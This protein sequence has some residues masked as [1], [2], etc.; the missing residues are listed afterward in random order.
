MKKFT[1]RKKELDQLQK[2]IV[3]GKSEFIAVYGR[4]RIGKTYLIRQAFSGIFTFHVTALSNADYLMQLANFNVEL[5]KLC[6]EEH[7]KP[8]S[9][10]LDAFES[11]RYLLEKNF[12]EKKRKVIFLDELPWFDT[13]NSGFIPALEH[14]WNHWAS[15][16]KDIIL[17]VCGSAA[18]WM[19]NK[20]IN[21]K[22]GLHNRITLK[23][24]VFP[25][26]LNE[27][28][29][30]LLSD[31]MTLDRYQITQ[32]YMVL[33]G[34]PFYWDQVVKGKSAV[35]NINDICFTE[36]GLLR[37]EFNNLFRSL[38]DNYQKHEAVIKAI[39]SKSSGLTRDDIIRKTG[40]PNAGST[41]RIL[42][43]LEESGFLNK[44]SPYGKKERNSL[45]QLTDNY[46]LFYFKFLRDIGK[47][48][49]AS[50]ITH[51]DTPAYRAWSGYAF[52]TIC[53]KHIDQIKHSLGISGVQTAVSSWRCNTRNKGVQIDL[54][55]DR[56][57]M[58]IN[59]CEMKF[60]VN[61]FV[62]NKKYQN[63]LQNKISL[64]REETGTRKALF[65]TFITTFG[66]DSASTGSGLVQNS[67][68]LD[69]LFIQND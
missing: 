61:K 3:S 27:C 20:L 23:I 44:F 2:A 40:L 67:L 68:T 11:L 18:S 37:N 59:I 42:Q 45:Y 62:I 63:I 31:N 49:N 39:A 6:P 57:D 24:K 26:T 51:F 19:I 41:T 46:P 60:S 66:I 10:W 34:V 29:Q 69:N 35:Q 53:L 33:G 1:G 32:L 12:P 16:R 43:E 7:I 17:V 47:D 65:L 15:A 38:F 56:R 4:R 5:F 58:T 36:T 21:N 14:F 48:Q 50:W 30:F 9:G 64:F 22:G 25:F 8:P 52:E 28:E 13:H 54:L 55:I